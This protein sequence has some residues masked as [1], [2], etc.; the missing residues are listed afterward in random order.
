MVNLSI[1]RAAVAGQFYPADPGALRRLVRQYLDEAVLPDRLHDVRA[2]IAPHAGYIYSGP[3][4]GY[5]FKALATLPQKQWTVFLLGPSHRSYFNGIAL[6]NYAAFRT[7]LGDAAVAV[8]R[9]AAMTKHSDLFIRGPEAHESEHCL[10]VEI[11]FL[12][13]ALPD[14]QLVPML[15]GNVDPHV[16]ATSLVEFLNEDVLIVVSSDLSHYHSYARARELDQALLGALLT[17]NQQSVSTGEAC[18]RAPVVTAMHLAQH[19]RWQPHLLDY[20][21]SGDTGGDKGQVVGYASVAY[22][23]A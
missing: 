14:F 3:I 12:Q 4:A 8:D 20:R 2:V 17:G 22:T 13:V 15:F 19:E 10:E 1:R 5:A 16:A 23:A 21:S 7:P 11:P 18:G 9:V 6:G